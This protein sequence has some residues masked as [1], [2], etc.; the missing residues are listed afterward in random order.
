MGVEGVSGGKGKKSV[1]DVCHNG[2]SLFFLYL[3][4]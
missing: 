4:F 3:L 1:R 2:L